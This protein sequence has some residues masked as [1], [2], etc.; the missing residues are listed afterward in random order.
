MMSMRRFPPLKA[1]HPLVTERQACQVCRQVFIAGDV[2]TLVP[3]HPADDEE[4]EKM[5]T[6]RAYNAVAAVIHADCLD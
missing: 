1:D 6:G 2:V 5:R 4:A 3:Q